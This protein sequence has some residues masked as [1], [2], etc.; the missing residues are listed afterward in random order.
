MVESAPE[1]AAVLSVCESLAPPGTPLTTAEVA[2]EFDCTDRTIYNKLDALV[3]ASELATKKVGARARVWWVPASGPPPDRDERNDDLLDRV[4]EVSPVGIVVVDATGDIVLAN[5]RAEEILGLKR[6]TITSRTYRDPDWKIYHEDGTP[7]TE[8]EHPVTRVFET[9]EPVFGFEHSIVRSDATERWLSSNS[10]PLFDESGSVERVVVGLEDVTRQREREAEIRTQR[11]ELARLNRVNTVIRSVDRAIVTSSSRDAIEREVCERLATSD[12]YLFAVIGEFSSTYEEF[13]P[14]AFAGIG[15]PYLRRMLDEADSP[16][17]REGVGATAARTREVQ[18]VQNLDELSEDFWQETAH[19]AGFQS[20][21]SIPIVF[22]EVV[23]GVL[24]VYARRPD[25]F[26]ER[27]RV[28]LQELGEII[29]HAINALERKEALVAETVVELEF[30]EAGAFAS[31]FQSMDDGA[32]GTLEVER[33]VLLEGGDALQYFTVTG[34]DPSTV[35]GALERG[36]YV[37]DVRLVESDG[38]QTRFEVRTTG[39]TMANVLATL[40]GRTRQVRFVDGE[41][42]VVVE[43]PYGVDVRKVIDRIQA[44]YPDME[45]VSRKTRDRQKVGDLTSRYT[46]MLTERQ[47]VVLE[48]AYAAGYFEWPRDSTGDELAH[49][50]DIASS[51]FHKHLR[52]AERKLLDALLDAQ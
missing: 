44:L 52:V 35:R 41:L 43:L 18:A 40:G 25:A 14:R 50:L 38:E 27:E 10:A 9:G 20:Y 17:L 48:A 37:S 28:V 21:A 15:E 16:S 29:G 3:E 13:T 47:R 26:D 1:P 49:S 24:G 4:I 11:D 51:T 2:A 5:Q 30:R 42:R 34:M 12:P 46:E 19:S 45:F 22:E 8:A 31:V 33:T 39:E 32:G 6:T 36:S 23:Y 7:V